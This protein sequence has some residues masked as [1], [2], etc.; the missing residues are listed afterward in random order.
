M[1]AGPLSANASNSCL[2]SNGT[3]LWTPCTLAFPRGVETRPT[4]LEVVTVSR[5]ARGRRLN[6]RYR[7]TSSTILAKLPRGCVATERTRNQVVATAERK[8]AKFHLPSF[9]RF[10]FANTQQIQN[11]GKLCYRSRVADRGKYF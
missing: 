4:T 1:A 8:Y 6:S 10:L 3:C 9:C 7:S 11:G 2:I 5:D